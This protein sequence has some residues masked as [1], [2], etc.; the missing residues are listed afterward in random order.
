MLVVEAPPASL[1]CPHCGSHRVVKK[2]QTVMLIMCFCLAC[3]QS[4]ELRVQPPPVGT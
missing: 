3:A 2:L 4:F 1:R